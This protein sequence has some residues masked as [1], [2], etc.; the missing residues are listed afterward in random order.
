MH[1]EIENAS[2][3]VVRKGITARTTML[4]LNT[5]TLGIELLMLALALSVGY[6]LVST[7]PSRWVG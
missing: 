2:W 7:D 6:V 3:S 4:V 1:T 5:W